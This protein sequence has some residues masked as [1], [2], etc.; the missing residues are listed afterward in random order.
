MFRLSLSDWTSTW[1]LT[2]APP[3]FCNHWLLRTLSAETF[4]EPLIPS[5][6][7]TKKSTQKFLRTFFKDLNLIIGSWMIKQD[8]S[9]PVIEVNRVVSSDI[10]QLISYYSALS[11]TLTKNDGIRRVAQII[12]PWHWM[13]V[14]F[15]LHSTWIHDIVKVY[16][17]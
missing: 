13:K 4:N 3:L 17:Q 11:H 15:S 7:L 2:T 5:A 6:N 16:N 9:G 1:T 14:S 8:S 12:S 10:G